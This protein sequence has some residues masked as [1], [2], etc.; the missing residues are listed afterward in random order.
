MNKL[1]QIKVP[2]VEFPTRISLIYLIV[3]VLWITFS[4]RLVELLFIDP[5]LLSIVQTIKGWG[6][7]LVTAFLLYILT[8]KHIV[9]LSNAQQELSKREQQYQQVFEAN[10]QP[11]WVYDPETLAFVA[12]NE[13]AIQHYGYSRVEF[14]HMT[15]KDIRPESEIPEMISDVSTQTNQPKVWK[16]LTKNGTVIDVEI[17][18]STI[19]VDGQ[20]L[21]LVLAR[22]ITR[23]KAIENRLHESEQMHRTLI[24][25]SP[26]AVIVYT[27]ATIRFIN[28][29]GIRLFNVSAEDIV[30]KSIFEFLDMNKHE[31]LAQLIQQTS[32]FRDFQ[33]AG[34]LRLH[35]KNGEILDLEISSS[36]MI[37]KGEEATQAII[38]N[39]SHRK[40]VE[41]E[42]RDSEERFR[43]MS[44]ANIAGTYIIQDQL[45]QYANPA[46]LA[47][48][49]YEESEVI[50]K[51]SP[52]DFVH[53]DD[54]ERV[55][56]LIE[57]RLSNG[58]LHVSYTFKGITKDEKV[59]FIE[60]FSSRTHYLSRSAL[61]DRKSVV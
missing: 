55:A 28:P 40:Q 32:H 56:R 41:R 60:V 26:D 12:V 31:D 14:L 37:F 36:H 38:R 1:F 15:L 42:L 35:L 43:I 29:A 39:V 58:E 59:V 18:A 2:N 3:S 19:D 9:A 24:D 33:H 53:P 11:M 51:L 27:D 57:P 50:G 34:E 8:R 49:S 52:M 20:T 44:E 5:K 4:D 7:V 10:P 21:R 30:D 61:I 25:S 48:F 13:V 6:F 54:R 22:D 23:I 17:R 45:V 46:L 47:T 16:H